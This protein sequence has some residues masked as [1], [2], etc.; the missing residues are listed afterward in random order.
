VSAGTLV[1][2]AG[3]DNSNWAVLATRSFAG[4][5]NFADTVTTSLKYIRCRISVTV[6]GGTVTAWVAALG[7]IPND[8]S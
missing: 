5:T 6:V 3:P 2:E 4:S 8:A 1:I 7:P